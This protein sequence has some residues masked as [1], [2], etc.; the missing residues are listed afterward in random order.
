MADNRSLIE[1]VL[2]REAALDIE[3]LGTG[4]GAGIVEL[5]LYD[6]N[7]KTVSQFRIAP[8]LTVVK[9]AAK[10]QDISGMSARGG[11]ILDEHPLIKRA[12][13]LQVQNDPKLRAV[14]WR[15][16]V[17]A[18]VLMDETLEDGLFKKRINQRMGGKFPKLS[19]ADVAG[20]SENDFRTYLREVQAISNEA[21][22][23]A[24]RKFFEEGVEESSPYLRRALGGILKPYIDETIQPGK[25]GF[26][27]A[28]EQNL[29]A[30]SGIQDLKLRVYDVTPEQ[31]LDPNGAFLKGLTNKNIQIA[32]AA[33]ESKQIG[34]LI[35]VAEQEIQRRLK[36]KEITS[37][38]AGRLKKQMSGIRRILA[39]TPTGVSDIM[40]ISGAKVNKARTL[41]QITGDY[42][43][44]FNPMLEEMAKG[45]HATVSD[46][47]D[48][49]KIQSSYEQSVGLA[50]KGTPSLLSVDVAQRLYGFSENMDKASLLKKEYHLGAY[51][52]LSQSFISRKAILQTQ[53]LV[54]VQ[55]GGSAAQSLIAQAKQ[56]KG[57]LH[58]AI[59]FS[60]MKQQA[61]AFVEESN[62]M[63]RL[64]RAAENIATTG[65]SYETSGRFRRGGM[66]ER[67]TP[68]GDIFRVER[69]AP[70][71]KIKMTSLNEVIDHIR[72]QSTYRHA[73]VDKAVATFVDEIN[74]GRKAPV[75][76]YDAEAKKLK[77]LEGFEKLGAGDFKKMENVK[78]QYIEAGF[79]KMAN[80][81]EANQIGS[82]S[83]ESI[84]S[85][86]EGLSRK[87]TKADAFKGRHGNWKMI[88]VKA[89]KVKGLL[90]LGIA[91]MAAVGAGG[92]FL[93]GGISNRHQSDNLRTMNYQRWFEAN[94]QFHG[95]EEYDKRDLSGFSERG[96][97]AVQRKQRTDFGS[98][99]QGPQYSKYV[100][101]NQ[102]LMDE[103]RKY[104][105]QKFA[106]VHFSTEGQIGRMLDSAMMKK[107]S[108]MSI[109][110]L[111]KSFQMSS[112]MV[113]FGSPLATEGQVVDAS[114]YAGMEGRQLF[115]VDLS[116]Y[117]MHASDADTIV[118]QKKG[119]VNAV[120]S[121]FGM[122]QENISIRLAGIDAPETAHGNKQG[123]PLANQALGRLRS[124]MEQGAQKTELL[125]DP[126]NVTYGRQVGSLFIDGQ[127]VQLDLI[128]SGA[129]KFLD[130]NKKGVEKQFRVDAYSRASKI[131]E[132][133]N[134]GI[135]SN[136]YFQPLLDFEKRSK[137]NV[138]FNTMV[139]LPKI[140][141]N[142]SLMSLY[143]MMH[144][145]DQTGLYT[146]DMQR[147]VAELADR[148]NGL[149]PDYKTP[150]IFKAVNAPHKA[151]IEQLA[152]DNAR[153]IKGS[154]KSIINSKQR[155][156]GY[157]NLDKKLTLDTMGTS[158]SV[159]SKRPYHSFE[160]FR[161]KEIVAQRRAQMQA[162][163]KQTL[164]Q[165]NQSPIGHHRM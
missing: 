133:S 62:I 131:A 110:S 163:Q 14:N 5:S 92:A 37:A 64:S 156:S 54:D 16:T 122:G 115:K 15:D 44:L 106:H 139:S 149:S 38:E 117:R 73:D 101:D 40:P 58:E 102:M 137:Q 87:A 150:S 61:Q 13:K 39:E 52:V 34:A 47:L 94:A 132:R 43:K 143:G 121:F 53:A 63:T 67:I 153:L 8:N 81:A 65:S 49:I 24:G 28:L 155:N 159:Q 111:M 112:S 46:I 109:S 57:A 82:I 2:A 158:T 99:Y 4:R 154:G 165:L 145:A 91:A 29:R 33:F 100:A 90:G 51:D 161:T 85:F 75:M 135:Y 31:L 77:I 48:L 79:A 21:K 146:S 45:K 130:F 129:A 35:A 72:G 10:N 160:A 6:P 113:S 18:Q 147:E 89:G 55:E 71:D 93:S 123:M 142:S 124:M 19:V 12:R 80:M 69:A 30:Y 125:I 11:D 74:V 157:G 36:A 152:M 97:G 66:V 118:L 164:Y 32:N 136:P 119:I 76:S 50:K 27:A 104:E 140:A 9:A 108:E 22:V 17:V 78:K 60:Q 103:R 3:T 138:T 114:K 107:G 7:T 134:F 59:V 98:P 88:D 42:T 86:I 126:S 20:M 83:P 68:E 148:N 144:A 162:L 116:K 141:Q 96:M 84:D 127:N 56:G 1:Q 70:T 120:S 25:T 26:N 95:L 151:Y 105:M 23:G 41:A 128:K